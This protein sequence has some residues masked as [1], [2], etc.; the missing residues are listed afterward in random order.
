MKDYQKASA[1]KAPATKKSGDAKAD[2]RCPT[3]D[4]PCAKVSMASQKTNP[5]RRNRD[6]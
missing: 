3:G 5:A 1:E 6:Y 4:V 2:Y